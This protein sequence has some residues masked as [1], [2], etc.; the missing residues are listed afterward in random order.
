MKAQYHPNSVDS[1]EVEVLDIFIDQDGR[2]MM[3]F[4]GSDGA[5]STAPIGRF[6]ELRNGTPPVKQQFRLRI[7]DTKNGSVPPE[8]PR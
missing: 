6:T 4:L 8:N 1:V 3:M 5:V 2:P 7:T